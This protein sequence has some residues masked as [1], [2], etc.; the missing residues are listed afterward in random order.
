MTYTYRDPCSV[1]DWLLLN[2]VCLRVSR[3][4]LISISPA[5]RAEKFYTDDVDRIQRPGRCSVIGTLSNHDGDGNEN[6]TK[7]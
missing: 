4:E 2:Y 5:D 1:S 6:V 3:L 7:Q